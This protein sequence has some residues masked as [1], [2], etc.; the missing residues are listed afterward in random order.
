VPVLQVEHRQPGALTTALHEAI[1]FGTLGCV[2]CLVE[3]CGADVLAREK[4]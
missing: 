3:E 1:I 2:R 4:K